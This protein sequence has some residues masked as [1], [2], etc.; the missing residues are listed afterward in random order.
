MTARFPTYSVTA[1][2]A[3]RRSSAFSSASSVNASASPPA[4]ENTAAARYP[5][6]G[7]PKPEES[8]RA[9]I[10]TLGRPAFSARRRSAA[11]GPP[12][13][14]MFSPASALR[15]SVSV[16]IDRMRVAVSASVVS[17]RACGRKWDRSVDATTR[18]FRERQVLARAAASVRM[19]ARV[20]SPMT[21]GTMDAPGK[22]RWTKGT[23][24]STACSSAKASARNLERAAPAISA[25]RAESTRATPSGVSKPPSGQT[26]TPSNPTRCEGATM[27]TVS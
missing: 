4:P 26:E 25:A 2:R 9:R 10:S 15:I 21:M 5:T 6:T 1:A 19:V 13:H 16:R 8:V 24:T 22:A 23:W 3:R 27:T 11:T 12:P 18:T 14:M 20:G 7:P 17:A